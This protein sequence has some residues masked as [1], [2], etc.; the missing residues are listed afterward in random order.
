[1][2]RLSGPR[3]AVTTAAV[4]VI[5]SNAACSLHLNPG[6]E[7]LR[8]H[9]IFV[10][11]LGN[12]KHALTEREAGSLGI[13]TDEPMSD[14]DYDAYLDSL[15]AAAAASDAKSILIYI[16]G[17]RGQL[18]KTPQMN[19]S[20]LPGMVGAGYYPIFV[21][22]DSS[23]RTSLGWHVFRIRNGTDYG[24]VLG[25]LTSPGVIAVDLARGVVRIPQTALQQLGD[26]CRAF[27]RL[28][29]TGRPSD[30]Y[31]PL[32]IADRKR[33][34]RL[35]TID[36]LTR[37]RF[38]T[39]QL[40]SDPRD[41][42]RLSWG[43]YDVPWWERG[44]RV[45]TSNPVIWFTVNGSLWVVPPKVVTGALIDGFG[46]GEWNDMLR[47]T[48]VM[49]RPEREF[50]LGG[51]GPSTRHCTQVPRRALGA[52]ARL[53]DA[54][55]EAYCSG[56]LKQDRRIVLAGHSMGTIIA[57]RIL[58]EYPELPIDTV[59]YMAAAT[60]IDD[61]Q[62]SVIPF[63]RR[64]P[65]ARFFSATLQPFAEAGE[66]RGEF[67]GVPD[68]IVPRGTLLEW[69]DDYFGTAQTHLGQTAGKW[70]NIAP[71][72]NVFPDDVR[73]RVLVKAFGH[74]D[75][76]DVGNY[77]RF[78]KKPTQHGHFS[79]PELRFYCPDF[80]AIRHTGIP[81]FVPLIAGAKV[82]TGP[83]PAVGVPSDSLQ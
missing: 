82:P 2:F 21:N 63:L 34:A 17:G 83:C 48:E 24:R 13:D 22:W 11:S 57:N 40:R 75:P 69:I 79:D 12:A 32:S 45:L 25:P 41:P 20:L 26:V 19:A 29:A 50:Q 72:L 81:P 30:A 64:N 52:T 39:T 15:V 53:M 76:I 35:A 28:G 65:N 36:S 27:G 80:W 18:H 14:A 7:H 70:T 10:G 59:Y 58:R 71:A 74:R 51:S 3:V 6:Q 47:R 31:C 54:L 42:L 77:R 9:G 46:T 5:L 62:A 49:F 60:S 23:D 78:F 66:R 61:M 38:T 44:Y 43:E 55:A 67:L 1:M 37:R 33:H 73:S 56:R 16:H 68:L 8:Q 4:S